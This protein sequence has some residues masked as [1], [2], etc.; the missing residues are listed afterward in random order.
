MPEDAPTSVPRSSASDARSSDAPHVPADGFDAIDDAVAALRRGELVIVVDD[1]AR[2]NEGDFIAAAE[3]V[4][5]ALVNFMVTRGRGLVCVSIPPERAEA[6]DLELM[7]DTN[8]ALYATPFTV[9]VDLKEG[10]TTGISASDRAKTIRAL[11]NPDATPYDFA[12]PGH[13]FPLRARTGGVLRRAGHTEAAVD[14]ARLAGCAPVGTLV[15]IMNDDGTMARVPELKALAKELAMPIITIEDLIAYR[16][17]HER[18]VDRAAEIDLA[19]AF[20][21]FRLVAFEEKLTGDAH[22]A[23]VKGTWDEDEPV[24]VR[25]HSQNVTGDVFAALR[26]DSRDQLTRALTQIDEAGQGVFLYM[27][28]EGRGIGLVNKL[29]AYK[30]QDEEGMDTVE[31]NRAL[32]FRM[33]PRDY[34]I[35]CQILRDLGVRKLRLMTNNPKKRVGISGGYGLEVVERVPIEVPPNAQNAHYLRTKRDRMGHLLRTLDDA[36]AETLAVGDGG[37]TSS[38]SSEEPAAS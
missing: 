11:A 38:S 4:T 14:L 36:A 6:L 37:V 13:V 15:E 16:M 26:D 28:Q 8:S 22:L 7:V 33:D 3:H 31:A 2:E 18:L 34:G 17:R 20:G 10:T 24:L 5:P 27:R 29:R 21:T 32:G 23:L 12:R 35:G 25:V 19:T 1:P 30:L 9:S